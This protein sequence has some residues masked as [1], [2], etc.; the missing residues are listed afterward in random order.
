MGEILQ[1]VKAA[2]DSPLYRFRILPAEASKD[3][4]ELRRLPIMLEMTP[5]QF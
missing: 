1:F 2:A 4:L 5:E 3:V